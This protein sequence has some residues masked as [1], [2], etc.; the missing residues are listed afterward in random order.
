MMHPGGRKRGRVEK[1]GH[2]PFPSL[3]SPNSLGKPISLS[4]DLAHHADHLSVRISTDATGS[5]NRRFGHYPFGETWYEAGK[6]DK[7][8]FTSYERDSESGLDYA[9]FRY[10]SSRLGRF[11]TPDPL[12]G[13]I[14]DPQSL[15]RYAYVR[16]DPINS[17][18]PL[19]LSHCQTV[20]WES[21]WVDSTGRH[22]TSDC[23]FSCSGDPLA[24]FGPSI[25]R[26]FFDIAPFISDL[27]GFFSEQADALRLRLPDE[28]VAD[29]VARIGSLYSLGG[30]ASLISGHDVQESLGLAGEIFLGNDA[31][32][33]VGLFGI[34]PESGVGV[35][36]FGSA[37][38]ARLGVGRPTTVGGNSP[39]RV[40]R[41][42]AHSRG[43][44]PQALVRAKGLA[45]GANALKAVHYK[46]ALD[47]TLAAAATL[48]CL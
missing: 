12:P 9:M 32:A 40:E 47:A 42:L 22:C 1:K 15:N 29:C 18:D 35:T 8:K 26:G 17:I 37:E 2:S 4:S 28:S 3:F 31:F 46:L 33:V 43:R 20:C 21:C 16:N 5:A 30:I 10:D 7:W 27:Y 34:G 11:M 14:S 45:K 19:G 41:L 6:V 25:P 38:S 24:G 36:G 39:Q 44:P 13:L 48:N 23:H